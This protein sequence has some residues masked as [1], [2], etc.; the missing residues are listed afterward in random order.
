MCTDNTTNRNTLV[1]LHR[2]LRQSSFFLNRSLISPD[3]SV[4]Y[5][6]PSSFKNPLISSCE[7]STSSS[8]LKEGEEGKRLCFF[9]LSLRDGW[10]NYQIYS[11]GHFLSFP[12]QIP[13]FPQPTGVGL[14]GCRGLQWRLGSLRN[15]ERSEEFSC[16]S[17]LLKRY[18]FLP[19][20]F[21]K[22][23]QALNHFTVLFM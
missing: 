19:F 16:T 23:F 9:T 3:T 12:C 10:C 8:P 17:S 7:L 13:W 2:T 22:A 18:N 20:L 15:G 4:E 1:N 14:Q 11:F 6:H 5:G 21:K